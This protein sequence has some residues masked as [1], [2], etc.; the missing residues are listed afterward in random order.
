MS[1]AKTTYNPGLSSQI[2]LKAKAFWA[3]LKFRL[4]FV[5]VTSALFGYFMAAGTE[6]WSLGHFLLLG[7]G[8]FLVTGASNAFNQVIE[9]EQDRLMVRTADRPMPTGM[10]TPI[11]AI[12]FALVI[13]GIGVWIL[14][15]YFNLITALLGIISLLLYAFVYTPLKRISSIAVLVGAI[16]G[17]MPPLIGWAAFTGGLEIE[18]WV[19]FLFQFIWQ[20]PHFWAIAWLL[21]EDYEKAGFKMLPSR[22]GKSA[23][24][25]T[26]ILIY[27]ALLLPI[28]FLPWKLGMTGLVLTALL[29]VLGAGFCFLAFRLFKRL[30]NPSARHLMLGSFLYLLVMQA[31]MIGGLFF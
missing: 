2:V 24:T 23:Y 18:G 14:G 7:L 30:D 21:H 1:E 22:T 9:T 6:A 17:A 31:I 20:F 16:P 28:C 5:V 19:L 27:T 4:S 25:A 3:L 15:F 10:L 8:G 13:G 12:A 11:E 26:L 29:L